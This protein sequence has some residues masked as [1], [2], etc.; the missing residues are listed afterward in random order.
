MIDRERYE[1]RFHDVECRAVTSDAAAP[2]VEGYAAVFNRASQPI[3]VGPNRRFVETIKPGAFT[4]A[5]KDVKG[6]ANVPFLIDHEG[7]PLADTRTGT[8]SL[9]QDDKGLA[10]RA[11]L[12]PSDPDVQRLM[13]KITRGLV[14]GM[15]FGFHVAEGGDNWTMEKGG[16]ACRSISDIR[17]LGDISATSSPAY[18]DAT[19][20]MR[21]LTRWEGDA[22]LRAITKREDI[23]PDEG[24]KKYGDVKF[25]DPVN[26]KYPIDSEEH[27]RAAW[28]YINKGANEEKYTAEEVKTIK[29]RIVAAWKDKIDK[30]GPP[31]AEGRS[32][33]LIIAR[34]RLDLLEVA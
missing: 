7:L 29:D 11:Q 6:G 4:T 27:I 28:N 13:P 5:L 33:R 9:S 10:F 23:N 19:L 34:R 31:S 26:K 25:A 16:T 18:L 22:D 3:P 24:T 32:I 30:A 1:F 12:D 8:L 20:A 14:N 21:S 17:T 2:A 15:S